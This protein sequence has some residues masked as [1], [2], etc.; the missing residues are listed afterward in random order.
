[1]YSEVNDTQFHQVE[2]KET[3]TSFR[4]KY[5]II[6]FFQKYIE[7]GSINEGVI[8]LCII[9]FGVGLLALPQK[10]QYLTLFFTP[11]MIIIFAIIN[12]WTFSV[13]GKAAR[14]Y[15]VN[16]YEDIISRLFNSYFSYFFNFVICFGL[17]GEIILFQV[18]LYKFI[19]GIIN[20]IF[21]Y[22]F[23][24]MEIFSVASFWGETK[25]RLI[26]CYSI[27]LFIFSPLCMIKTL[28]NLRYVTALGIFS[29][30]LVIFIVVIQSPMFYHHNVIEKKMKINFVDI[31]LGFG[32][33]FKFITSI[34]T[35]VYAYECHAGIFPV[36]SALNNPNEN[37][38]NSVFRRAT[39]INAIA[40]IIITLSGYI[41]QPQNTP[42]LIIEREKITNNDYLMSLGLIFFT[43]TIIIKIVAL[44]NCLRRIILNF[45]KY[46][47]DNF[48]NNIN[49]I[50]LLIIFSIT[51]FVAAIFQNISDYISLI[52]SFYGLFIAVIIPG[53]IY[54][55][56]D[57]TPF[58]NK[59]YAIMFISV[60]SLIGFLTIYFIL[61]K[62][63]ID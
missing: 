12:Y 28:S 20:E 34:S 52:S 54:I 41:S 2:I 27:V 51:T 31:S 42:D 22:G 23:D 17:F 60:L 25:I 37:R 49:F 30:F 61:K 14:R 63:L 55:K 50:L 33:D 15:N 39:F 6:N 7:K 5:S 44:F 35:I 18:I 8:N 26:V 36:I 11:I 48:P 58:K 46:N 19:G 24:N 16:K 43:L 62:I 47:V 3:F 53:I 32:S 13:L 45:M 4:K 1:M 56:F 21:S 29:V 38:V 40:Y 59:C 10:V 57:E 9:S